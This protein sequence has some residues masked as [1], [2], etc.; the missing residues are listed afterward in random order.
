MEDA[1]DEAGHG[2]GTGEGTKQGEAY[3]GR[4]HSMTGG[5]SKVDDK[6]R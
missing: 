6:E 3:R 2:R 4:G 5:G 1:H